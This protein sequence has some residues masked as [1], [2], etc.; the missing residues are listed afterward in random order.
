MIFCYRQGILPF[1]MLFV[2]DHQPRQV[3]MMK[4][5]EQA[6]DKI[7]LAHFLI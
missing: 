3:P 5:I 2:F 7:G 6:I 4:Q 1:V